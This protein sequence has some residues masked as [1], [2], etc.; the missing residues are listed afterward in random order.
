MEKY[1]ANVEQIAFCGLYCGSCRKFLT[2]KCPGCEKNEKAAWC[3]IRKC[4]IEKN[5]KSCAECT[6]KTLKECKYFTNIIAS[7]FSFV[8]RSDRYKCI[9]YIKEH[10]YES[11]SEY[12]AEE[13]KM[14]MP[15]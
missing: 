15:K 2:D 14:A 9:D 6:E 7:I 3:K 10:G 4:C 1:S 12:M 5:L 11:F 8:F 13:K